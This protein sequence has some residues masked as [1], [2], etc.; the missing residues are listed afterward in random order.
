M[1]KRFVNRDVS[2]PS[3]EQAPIVS[4]PGE[5][6]FN[7]PALAVPAQRAAILLCGSLAAASMRAEQ[8]DPAM[9]E[10]NPVGI[11]VI[12]A[13][14]DQSLGRRR[15]MVSMAG[16]RK[17]IVER[18][19]EQRHF[20]R[21]GRCQ[22]DPQ[23]NSLAVRHHHA[24]C[25]LA[26]LR[27][28]DAGPLFFAGMNVA[29]TNASSQSSRPDLVEVGEQ[30]APHLDP[31]TLLFPIAK[32]TLAGARRRVQTGEILPAR[33]SSQDPQNAFEHTPRVDRSPTAFG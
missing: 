16:R 33:S 25:S 5:D 27:L 15:T 28:A 6:P 23:R 8:L 30:R 2:L 4:Q 29:S 7:L 12:R 10:A 13:I 31:H 21:R 24:L 18:R 9:R 14:G 20:R 32:P 17:G 11:G 26:T 22:P 3:D 1:Q 19:F